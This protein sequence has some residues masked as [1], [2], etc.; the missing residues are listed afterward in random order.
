MGKKIL[1]ILG[2]PDNESF[3]AALACAYAEGAKMSGAEV[4]SVNISDLRFDPVLHKGYRVIQEL[5]PDLVMMQEKIK[6]SDHIV[7]VYP[8]WWGAMPALLKGL[9]ERIILPGFA[10]RFHDNGMG[11]SKYLKGKSAR[12]IVTMNSPVLVYK[13]FFGSVGD[14]LLK[15]AILGFC[16]VSPVK[17]THIDSVEKLSKEKLAEWISKIGNLGRTL[18]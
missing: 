1:V 7:F 17:I 3:C 9:M 5:E 4:A 16:G 8:T 2:H 18:K 11:W 13:L 6:A 15:G 12:L 10:Y 14:K